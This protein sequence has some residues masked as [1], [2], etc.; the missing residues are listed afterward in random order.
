M[1]NSVDPSPAQRKLG[2]AV[3][4]YREANAIV[5]EEEIGYVDTAIR[6]MVTSNRAEVASLSNTWETIRTF[7]LSQ[8]ESISLIKRTAEERW[9]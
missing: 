9:T 2:A 1:G 7:A 4:R 8:Q 6:G 5:D 3:R